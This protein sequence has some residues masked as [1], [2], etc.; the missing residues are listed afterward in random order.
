MHQVDGVSHSISK[1][2]IVAQR[3]YVCCH[4]PLCFANVAKMPI[5]GQVSDLHILHVVIQSVNTEAKSL[6]HGRSLGLVLLVFAYAGES[7]DP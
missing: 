6:D 5:E 1:T 2:E 3:P 7:V 4:P